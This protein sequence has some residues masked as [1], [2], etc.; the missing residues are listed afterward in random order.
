MRFQHHPDGQIVI[1]DFMYP[2]EE[3]RIDEPEYQLPAGVTGREYVPGQHHYTYTEN[4]SFPQPLQWEE[5]DLYITQAASYEAAFKQRQAAAQAAAEQ[6]AW[7]QMSYLDKRWT[8]YPDIRRMV[9]ALLAGGDELEAVKAAVLT[10]NEKYP[11]S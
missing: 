8:E 2:L 7:E 4:A 9:L 5:G 10:V 11:K 1:N 3:F 6:A